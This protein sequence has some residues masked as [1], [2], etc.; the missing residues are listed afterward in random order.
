MAGPALD[1]RAAVA[2]VCG[3]QL[4]QQP[5][6]NSGHPSTDGQLHPFQGAGPAQRPC[7]QRRQA[8]YL[9]RELLPERGEEPPF[10]PAVPAGPSP[11]TGE[12]G[13]AWQIASLTS[14]ISPTICR[15]CRYRPT[16][17][18]TFSSSGPS[19]RCADTVLPATFL[20]KMCCGP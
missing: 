1:P 16:S 15:N 9:G 7:S 2:G 6:A 8:R 12:I 19:L 5:A 20:V 4:F 17:P 11:A 13:R 14:T 10:S 3:Q 18:A